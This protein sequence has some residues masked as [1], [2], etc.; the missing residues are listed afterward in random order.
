MT[1][2]YTS[3]DNPILIGA[4]LAG[5]L[6]SIY[7]AKKGI[8][9]DIYERRPDMRKVD[10]SAGRSINLALSARGIYALEEV[11]LSDQILKLAIPMKG[12]MIH[13]PKG[14]LTYQPYGKD[15]TEY[16]N[17]ISRGQ[18]NTI[19]MNTAEQTENVTIH[20]NNR[21]TGMDFDTGELSIYDEIEKKE[22]K[23]KGQPIIG[24]DGSASAIRMD[25]IKKGRYDY[26]QE[27]L[28]HCYKEL[29]IPPGDNDT[30]IIE[31][32]A[33]HIWPRETFMMIAL[34][35]LDGSF[36]CTIFLP[37]TGEYAF[38]KLDS[39]EK[40]LKFY[41]KHFS[42]AIPL[43]PTLVDDFFN[44][45]TSNLVT[46]KCFPW[47]Y[48]DKALILGDAAHAIIPFYGQGMN[49]A[50][51]DCTYL[52]QFISKFDKD[53]NKI[54]SEFEK[55]RKPN[56]DAIAELSNENFTEMRDK[57]ANSTFLI[58]KQAEKILEQK[59]PDEF[60]SVY[61][62]V[63]FHRVPYSIAVKK[64]VIQDKLLMETCEYLQ[65]IEELNA[66]EMMIRLRKEFNTLVDKNN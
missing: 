21:C 26:T 3:E 62:M 11:G 49:C 16:I 39:K 23:V 46:I 27:Y 65:S 37:Y 36:T 8:L 20:F 61:S 22:F 52:N 29:T 58:K 13:S 64:G 42:D 19:L 41:N 2:V 28:M 60:M 40:L 50:F 1:K 48:Q 9:V 55:E 25:M 51:E 12:R 33:L 5:S 17:S 38:D 10:I 30:H 66:E 32:N 31:K 35:N 44:N 6:L 45:P 53:W 4:G 34:P 63:S 24:T 54:F 14:E 43:M 18:L 15:D 56:V 59:Y 47:H 7:L 57:V